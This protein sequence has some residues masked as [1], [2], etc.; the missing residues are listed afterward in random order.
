MQL[1]RVQDEGETLIYAADLIPLAS[2]VPLAWIMGYDLFPVTTLDEKRKLL[3]EA[4]RSNWTLMFEHDPNF[5][6]GKV[7]ENDKGFV[8]K[9]FADR[10]T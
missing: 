1:V 3:T 10:S 2:Q 4:V 8:F 6:T 9:E 5:V 7:V